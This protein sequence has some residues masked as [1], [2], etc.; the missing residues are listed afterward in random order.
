MAS[1]AQDTWLRYRDLLKE[2]LESGQVLGDVARE[3]PVDAALEVSQGL[4]EDCAEEKASG[5]EDPDTADEQLLA[6]AMIDFLLT[7]ELALLEARESER[8]VDAV[9]SRF[10]RVVIWR[11]AVRLADRTFGLGRGED[12]PRGGTLPPIL[13]GSPGDTTRPGP[14][15]ESALPF[16]TEEPGAPPPV[17][18]A[19]PG[20]NADELRDNCLGAATEMIEFGSPS[21]G[22]AAA[23]LA[24]PVGDLAHGLENLVP[25]LPAS[26]VDFADDLKVA[27]RRSLRAAGRFVSKILR[28]A[29]TDPSEVMARVGV[30]LNEL[31]AQFVETVRELVIELV[32]RAAAGYEDFEAAVLAALACSEPSNAALNSARDANE[33][34]ETG[35]KRRI[36]IVRVLLRGAGTVVHALL[37]VAAPVIPAV[38]ML[39][40][41]VYVLYLLRSRLETLPA[42]I[43]HFEGIPTVART[44]AAA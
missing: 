18:G 8:L 43:Q 7:G 42:G 25:E 31:V 23:F 27:G 37:A 3:P 14:E 4:E 6:G 17:V 39:T 29:G 30:G 32:V 12:D 33:N 19:A 1:A 35:F 40:P 13:P 28:A 16:P 34:I 36:R 22:R 38:T 44:Y 11:A 21:V 10:E 15:R 9:D 5:V 41:M 26:L 2:V 24:G 20:P